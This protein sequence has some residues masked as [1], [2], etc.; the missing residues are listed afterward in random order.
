MVGHGGWGQFDKRLT[1]RALC[2]SYIHSRP[3][4]VD[5][6]CHCGS[7]NITKPFASSVNT[8]RGKNTK[9]SCPPVLIP[10]LHTDRHAD[11]ES[12]IGSDAI[13]VAGRGRAALPA[14]T[15]H[16]TARSHPSASAAVGEVIATVR[17]TVGRSTA[18]HPHHPFTPTVIQPAGRVCC[19]TPLAHNPLGTGR[20]C[21]PVAVRVPVADRLCQCV[22]LWPAVVWL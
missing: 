8:F 5:T 15:L 13:G 19:P 14:V 4:S 1:S 22:C 6:D 10:Q 18:T 12:L 2:V 11:G 9:N 3:Q 17:H 7:F 16:Y 21:V 20:Y